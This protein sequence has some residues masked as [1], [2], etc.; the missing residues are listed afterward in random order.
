M[1]RRFDHEKLVGLIETNS[2]DR[3]HEG[4]RLY[5]CDCEYEKIRK[6]LK[7]ARADCMNWRVNV[8]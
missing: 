3:L 2:V 6:N 7:S 1:N 5:D 8:N 4:N